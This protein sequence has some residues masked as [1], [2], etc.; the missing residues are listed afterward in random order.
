M[1][2]GIGGAGDDELPLVKGLAPSNRSAISDL[3][4]FLD[5][6]S[7]LDRVQLVLVLAGK[8]HF[9]RGRSPI[10]ERSACR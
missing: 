6:A 9:D 7:L 10:S 3:Q 8:E 4:D 5:R 1:N 2:E